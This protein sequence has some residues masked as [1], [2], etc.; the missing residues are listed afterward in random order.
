MSLTLIVAIVCTG[1]VLL[2]LSFIVILLVHE[3]KIKERDMKIKEQK[4]SYEHQLLN[5]TLEIAEED[6]NVCEL[7]FT[8]IFSVKLRLLPA[9]CL[10][11]QIIEAVTSSPSA[12]VLAGITSVIT[13]ISLVVLSQSAM[14]ILSRN[15]AFSASP[16]LVAPVPPLAIGIVSPVAISTAF[17]ALFT[18]GFLSAILY[19]CY[20]HSTLK[21]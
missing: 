3:K 2:I 19:Q 1:I 6:S 12:H 11:L 15:N 7:L 10:C 9:P 14:V 5:T 13:D 20:R 18:S 8:F 4:N 16:L 17:P 21:I